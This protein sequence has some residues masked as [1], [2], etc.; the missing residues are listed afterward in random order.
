VKGKIKDVCYAYVF[1][2][3]EDFWSYLLQVFHFAQRR[4]WDLQKRIVVHYNFHNIFIYMS[5]F[6]KHLEVALPHGMVANPFLAVYMHR[7]WWQ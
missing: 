4:R 5:P 3:S 7:E 2:S 1:T 6:E